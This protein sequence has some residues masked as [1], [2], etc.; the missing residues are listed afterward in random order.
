M[1][2]SPRSSGPLG[3]SCSGWE[4]DPD[5][6]SARPAMVAGTHLGPAAPSATRSGRSG[7]APSAR[8]SS[9]PPPARPARGFRPGARPHRRRSDPH[10]R[11]RGDR[12]ARSPATRR[13][14]RLVRARAEAARPAPC[15]VRRA[16]QRGAI[17]IAP[18]GRIVSPLSIAFSTMCTAS[19][20]RPERTADRRLSKSIS[21]F[22][23]GP[24]GGAAV[25]FRPWR[26]CARRKPAARRPAPGGD[27]ARPRSGAP[28][29][30]DGDPRSACR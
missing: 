22:A 30:R 16:R 3:W 13:G 12:A 6:R 25:F 4:S 15:P 29:S 9:T 27:P 24:D 18:S 5:G 14:S 21:R 23:P 10:R 2:A 1:T 20:S 19:A 11:T 7:R 17:R 26:S 8:A 28:C